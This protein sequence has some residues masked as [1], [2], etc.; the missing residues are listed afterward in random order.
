MTV[1]ALI[2]VVTYSARLR[3]IAETAPRLTIALDPASIV[4]P[5]D[6]ATVSTVSVIIPAYNEAENIEACVRSVLENTTLSTEQLDVWVV[7]DQSSDATLTIVQTLQQTLNDR[8][9]RV[10]VGKPRPENEI[11]S[12]KN[13][14]CVQA[15]T[16][17]TG[18]FL[19]FLDAD[20]RLKPGAIVAAVKTVQKKQVDLL[21]LCPEIVCGCL[22]EWLVQPWMMSLL[23]A[24]FDFNEVNDPDAEAAFAAGMFMLFRRTAYERLGGH[25]AVADQA[26]EDVELARRTKQK[27]L[28][29]YYAAGAELAS[30]RMYRSL[31]AVWEGWTKNWHLGSRRQLSTSLFS[32]TIMVWVCVLPWLALV[33][34]LYQS[35]T[36]GFSL[37]NVLTLVLALVAIGLQYD[38][39]RSIERVTA[40]PPR[41][42]WLTGVGGVL[43]AAIAII[44]IIKTE[45]GWGWTWRGRALQLPNADSNVDG[46]K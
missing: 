35:G 18:E 6:S 46:K 23:I 13:W 27:G 14:A 11:W 19:L 44:S 9:L 36:I 37:V 42:W 38:L 28:K 31:A 29:L 1:I 22:A 32:A 43:V 15:A 7:D 17:A 25:Q 40:M 20:V 10:L 26:V 30:V 21:T 34:T 2:G 12:G 33:A 39:R 24:G 4:P 8:R 5:D 41:Y 16:Q 3:R 45:T